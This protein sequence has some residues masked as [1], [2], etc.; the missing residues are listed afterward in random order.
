M[1]RFIISQIIKTVGFTTHNYNIVRDNRNRYT[2]TYTC[3]T[4]GEEERRKKILDF[5]C[6]QNARIFQVIDETR[7]NSLV[8]NM[9]TFTVGEITQQGTLSSF[10]PDDNRM[11][12]YFTNSAVGV[13]LES[14]NKR[15]VNPVA[16]GNVQT[17]NISRSTAASQKN[18]EILSLEEKIIKNRDIRLEKLLK[19]NIPKTVDEFLVKFFKTYN[20]E[21][22]TIYVD[23]KQLQTIAERRRSLGDIYKICKYYYPDV[24]LKEV[25]S[26]LYK[27]LPTMITD[28]F[29]TSYCSTINKRVWYY[30]AG[31]DN[32]QINQTYK[33]EYGNLMNWYTD[34]I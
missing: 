31:D 21:K 2:G 16:T 19:K 23:D 20:V 13:P 30:S 24:S 1:R 14:V 15:V 11:L 17:T 5:V 27:K 12:V 7:R 6:M 34:K 25:L 4:V 10:K 29:R 26:L 32:A 22:N 8:E 18:K 33:D 9:R 28:G 3:N